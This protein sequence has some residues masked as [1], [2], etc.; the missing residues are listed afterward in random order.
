MSPWQWIHSLGG[1]QFNGSSNNHQGDMPQKF[2]S[3][4]GACPTIVYTGMKFDDDY[5]CKILV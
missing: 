5:F 2:D 4:P 3:S 1:C